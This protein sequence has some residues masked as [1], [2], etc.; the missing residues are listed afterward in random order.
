[1]EWNQKSFFEAAGG[2]RVALLSW[3]D[4]HWAVCWAYADPHS[5]MQLVSYDQGRATQVF[6]A[7]RERSEREGA[8]TYD[9]RQAWD[10][11]SV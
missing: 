1:M 7:S 6:K 4:G 3:D 10:G 11:G 5:G 2:D 9:S 8:L